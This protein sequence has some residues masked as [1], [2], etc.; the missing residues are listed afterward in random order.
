MALPN[1]ASLDVSSREKI[2][3]QR[4]KSERI[5]ASS[6][7]TSLNTVMVMAMV[8]V[9]VSGDSDGDGDG[10]GN[11]DGDSDGDGNGDGNGSKAGEGDCGHDGNHDDGKG[12]ISDVV[13]VDCDGDMKMA[14]MGML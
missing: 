14:V 1:S 12:A 2:S 9:M 6:E 7:V 8:M 3:F 4:S 11:C 10:D 13:S 5:R